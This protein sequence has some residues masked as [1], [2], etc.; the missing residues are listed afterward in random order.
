MN[1]VE[2]PLL[3]LPAEIRLRI[4]EYTV[5]I[6]EPIRVGQEL[7]P[8]TGAQDSKVV[9]KKKDCLNLLAV[10]CQ[11]YQEAARLPLIVNIFRVVSVPLF[12]N[13]MRSCLRRSQRESIEKIWFS[14]WFAERISSKRPGRGIEKVILAKQKNLKHVHIYVKL[15][16]RDDGPPRPFLYE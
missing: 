10:C 4:W 1:S 15:R 12:E 5:N 13:C 2:S 3:R 9:N 8:N 11:T 6:D 14:T 16:R 7:V